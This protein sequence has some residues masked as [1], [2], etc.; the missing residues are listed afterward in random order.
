MAAVRFLVCVLACTKMAFS[1]FSRHLQAFS[2]YTTES[3]LDKMH[4]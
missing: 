4:V 1:L 2:V 3:W